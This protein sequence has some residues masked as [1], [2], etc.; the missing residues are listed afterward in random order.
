MKHPA[1]HRFLQFSP[2]V[3]FQGKIFSEAMQRRGQ[4]V[5][6]AVRMPKCIWDLPFMCHM[7]FPNTVM[8]G[9]C[10]K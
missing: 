4:Y 10:A 9:H 5:S 1:W 7:S 3:I 8:S 6:V 2:T